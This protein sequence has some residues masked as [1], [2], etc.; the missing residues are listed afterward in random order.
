MINGWCGARCSECANPCRLDEKI[1]CSPDCEFL[2]EHGEFTEGC[3][4]CEVFKLESATNQ[5]VK[6]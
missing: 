5:P 3:V 2:G 4:D 6:G 1:P